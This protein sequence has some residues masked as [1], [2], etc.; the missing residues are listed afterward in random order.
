V[1]VYNTFWIRFANE[2]YNLQDLELYE[3]HYTVM[4]YGKKLTQIAFE[5]F[6]PAWEGMHPDCPGGWPTVTARVHDMLRDVFAAVA[7]NRP[8]MHSPMSRA[9][10]GIDVMLTDDYQPRLLEFSFCPDTERATK[11]T[12]TYYD[13]CLGALFRG[14][15]NNCTALW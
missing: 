5:E 14:E 10:Y 11:F 2:Q 7:I 6:I 8:E 4:N 12:P 3:K 15:S 9:E 1:F 13:D